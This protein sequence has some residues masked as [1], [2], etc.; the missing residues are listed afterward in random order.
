MNMFWLG[1]VKFWGVHYDWG[2]RLIGECWARRK[3]FSTV[4]TFVYLWLISRYR[5]CWK[6]TRKIDCTAKKKIRSIGGNIR[7][8]EWEK[9]PDVLPYREVLSNILT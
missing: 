7:E 9:W 6:R 2:V 8:K 3:L 5:C 1:K 4:D